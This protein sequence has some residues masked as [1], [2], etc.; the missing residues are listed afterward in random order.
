MISSSLG[1]TNGNGYGS[2]SIRGGGSSVGAFGGNGN[3][4]IRDVVKFVT[5]IL[6]RYKKN[7]DAYEW[8]MNCL[9][10]IFDREEKEDITSDT[11]AIEIVLECANEHINDLNLSEKMLSLM[12]HIYN[13]QGK[14][15]YIYIYA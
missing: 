5:C 6:S 12:P 15:K 1:T 3:V 11:Y 7:K 13:R 8:G 14:K 9:T 2:A 4:S 10:A